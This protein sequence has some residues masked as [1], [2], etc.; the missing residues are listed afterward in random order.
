[1]K[2]T[3]YTTGYLIPIKI[4]IP[5]FSFETKFVYNIKSSL[6]LET[7]IDILLV[8]F[9]SSITRRTIKE[10]S[11][12]NVKELLKYQISHQIHY[13][14]SLINNPRIRDTSYDVPLI[15]SIEKESIS[16]KENIVLPSFINYEIEIFCNDFCIENNVSTEFSGEMSFSL[17]E[18]IMCFFANISQEMSENT[19]NVS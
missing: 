15:I 2:I 13:F 18:Q 7:F 5:L 10:S 14:N 6:N 4:S 12:K 9:K 16:I 1:M 3:E 8:E 17:R 11:L 19:S